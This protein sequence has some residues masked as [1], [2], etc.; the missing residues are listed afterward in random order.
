[1]GK[2][3]KAVDAE[4]KDEKEKDVLTTQD[5][6]DRE[7]TVI[8]KIQNTPEWKKAEKMAAKSGHK[9]DEDYI[10]SVYADL[11]AKKEREEPPTKDEEINTTGAD[12]PT[13]ARPKSKAKVVSASVVDRA[14]IIFL[15]KTLLTPPDLEDFKTLYP[16]LF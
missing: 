10:E 7:P 13:M 6:D 3:D 11:M 8:E 9:G 12:V 4:V 2:E 16:S 1:M 5:Q 14:A 15:A